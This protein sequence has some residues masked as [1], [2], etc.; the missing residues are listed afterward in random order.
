MLNSDFDDKHYEI[1]ACSGLD[2]NWKD[3]PQSSLIKLDRDTTGGKME[4]VCQA[5]SFLF[6]DS[7]RFSVTYLNG[8]EIFLKGGVCFECSSMFCLI[9]F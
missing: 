4:I 9:M 5:S 7:I 2:V 3:A 8:T 6:A 1:F